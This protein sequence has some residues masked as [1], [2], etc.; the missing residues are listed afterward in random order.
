MA[1]IISRTLRRAV[2]DSRGQLPPT[3]LL[4]WTANLST[5]ANAT[6]T[7]N[8]LPSDISQHPL[9]QAQDKLDR[10]ITRKQRNSFKSPAPANDAPALPTPASGAAAEKGPLEIS[11]EVREMLPLLRAQGPHYI[12]AHIHAHPYLLTQGDTLRLPFYMKGVEPG[13]VI[14]LDRA[15]HLGSRD[16]TLKAAVQSPKLKSPTMQTIEVL[17][18]TTGNLASHSRVMPEGPLASAPGAVAAPHFIPHIAKGKYPYL[19][20]R[21]FVCRAVVIGVESE[22][23]RIL[24][25]TKRRQRKVKNIKSKHRFTILKIKEVRLRTE[26]ELNNGSLN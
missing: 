14:R 26:D 1:S 6:E 4:P 5:T 16:Y 3:F 23:L 18:P 11:P 21:L 19:D 22:P 8:T 10:T 24:Q 25:K 9:R 20:D 2:L 7:S 17:D 12:S 13:D 15:T